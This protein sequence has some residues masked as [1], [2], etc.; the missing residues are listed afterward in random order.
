MATGGCSPCIRDS[1]A[2]RFAGL[3]WGQKVDLGVP[4]MQL[5]SRTLVEK[6]STDRT[7]DEMEEG[8]YAGQMARYRELVCCLNSPLTR[9]RETVSFSIEK[10]P[11]RY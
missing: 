4:A 1:Q 8:M 9:E 3:R 5:K 2:R 10:T 11:I 7:R 6:R